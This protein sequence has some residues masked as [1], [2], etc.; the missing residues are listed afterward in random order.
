MFKVLPISVEAP[1]EPV[2]VSI[3][4][5][6]LLLNVVQSVLLSKPFCE[7]LAVAIANVILP[8]V[9]IGELPIVTPLVAEVKPTLVTVPTYWSVY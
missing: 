1:D 5:P 3:I 6:C 9:V 7:P 2:V 4:A 8:L